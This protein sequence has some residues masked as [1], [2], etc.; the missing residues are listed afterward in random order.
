MDRTSNFSLPFF[1]SGRRAHK[2]DF[3]HDPKPALDWNPVMID[4]PLRKP[5]PFLES[6]DLHRR[7]PWTLNPAALLQSLS[8]SEMR[9]PATE[10][11]PEKWGYD[12][13]SATAVEDPVAPLREQSLQHQASS[14][15]LGAANNHNAEDAVS[16]SSSMSQRMNR[17][18]SSSTLR[19]YYDVKRTPLAISQQTSASAVRDMALRKGHAPISARSQGAGTQSVEGLHNRSEGC[20]RLDHTRKKRPARLD[21]SKLFPKPVAPPPNLLSPTKF[22]DSPSAMSGISEYFPRHASSH[23]PKAYGP[24]API[25][26]RPNKLSKPQR[27]MTSVPARPDLGKANSQLDIFGSTKV[28]IR[29]PPRGI[30][31]WF[32]GLGESTEEE[33]DGD[34]NPVSK[35]PST[36]E[37]A[38]PGIE[39]LHENFT[40]PSVAEE[41]SST[42]GPESTSCRS[43][44]STN[45]QRI[46]TISRTRR[47]RFSNSNLQDESVLALSSS[48]EEE[49]D[50][51][52]PPVRHSVAV[53]ALL[54]DK[55][56]IGRAQALEV[57][58]SS[59]HKAARTVHT[60][61]NSRPSNDTRSLAKTSNPD[62]VQSPNGHTHPA[63]R[64]SSSRRSGYTR[65]PSIVP[66]DDESSDIYG[67]KLV[68]I[69]SSSLSRAPSTQSIRNQARLRSDP[70]KLMVVTEEEEALLEMMRRKRAAMAKQSFTEGYKMALKL[71]KKLHASSTDPEPEPAGQTTQ[72]LEQPTE[73]ELLDAFPTTPS[74][75]SF[76]SRG[77]S[78]STEAATAFTLPS[79]AIT[80][81]SSGPSPPHQRCDPPALLSTSANPTTTTHSSR[82]A[83]SSQATNA[84]AS[85]DSSTPRPDSS[86]LHPYHLP[87]P[88][89]SSPLLS[90]FPSPLPSPTTATSQ[91]PMTPERRASADIQ[92]NVAGST[93]GSDL[94]PETSLPYI[95][96]RPRD[97]ATP[98]SITPTDVLPFHQAPA[99]A[100][101]RPKRASVLKHTV[102]ATVAAAIVSEAAPLGL[103]R[104]VRR[105]SRVPGA[106]ASARC[107]V[108]EDV[109]AAW[110]AL[111]GWRDFEHVRVAGL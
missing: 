43:H 103:E 22:V 11:Q 77:L 26:R 46:T 78:Q 76:H 109:L 104:G 100:A 90:L 27:E 95:P 32:D 99:D 88:K 79:T 59:A 21:L 5:D 33:S 65:Q 49:I 101:P 13:R 16:I 106:P 69:H 40:Q 29:R 42:I 80:Q 38:T 83:E 92:V 62:T 58:P 18:V 70:Q 34:S 102:A 47:N 28:N 68:T 9:I 75:T 107:S 98:K 57:R 52:L 63:S 1:T 105:V 61:C 8:D 37:L 30:Q 4:P 31:Y 6:R 94:D 82:E 87:R 7:P 84:P 14:N 108:S 91:G 85:N 86:E 36:G 19:S 24:P 96:D 97:D 67:P 74:S 111:G 56:L 45:S 15:V 73:S 72:N 81:P 23:A 44:A 54:D 89:A 50:S 39:M 93:L 17:Q 2:D 12:V 60:Q 20:L 10:R 35:Q 64:S 53:S 55:I 48:D 3:V 66:E 71:E 110:G 41:G 25:A 51:S